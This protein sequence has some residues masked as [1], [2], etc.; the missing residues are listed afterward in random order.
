M[1]TSAGDCLAEHPADGPPVL[2][3]TE[4]VSPRLS[5]KPLPGWIALR[6]VYLILKV[7]VSFGTSPV[8]SGVY[9]DGCKT[10]DAECSE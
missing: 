1:P 9:V 3:K 2:V 6:A 8:V 4:L 7:S 5:E 10:I